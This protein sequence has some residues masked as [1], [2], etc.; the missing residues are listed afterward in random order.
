MTADR[1]W[2]GELTEALAVA[3]DPSRAAGQQRYMKSAMPYHGITTP[4]LRSIL[5]PLLRRAGER[6]V[7]RA[8]WDDTVRALWDDASH[9]EQRYAAIELSGIRPARGWQD[10][11]TLAL[12]Q[13]MVE[14]GAWWDYVDTIASHRVGPIVRAERPT[15]SGRMLEWATDQHMWVRR[16][17]I[18]HQL[19]FKQA[20]DT[21]VLSGTVL[22]N[23][24]GSAFA[25]EF[26]IRK[27]IGWAL[28]EYARTDPAWV[29]G[30]VDEHRPH[31]SGLSVR[32]ATKH[33]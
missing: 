26:F 21:A 29:R 22:A 8:D 32:E 20:T 30:F 17:A 2:I 31:M 16:T 25:G 14:S 27:A 18:L 11:D 3:G 28:R 1:Q 10:L 6:L 13:H 15:A 7:S 12:Y 4:E 33:L 5:R 9:R 24:A 19:G 23:V